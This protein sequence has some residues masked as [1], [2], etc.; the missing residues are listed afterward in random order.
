MHGY[1]TGIRQRA[2]MPLRAKRDGIAIQKCRT[3]LES[4]AAL[5]ENAPA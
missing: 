5:G 3:G 4:A 2:E 1:A